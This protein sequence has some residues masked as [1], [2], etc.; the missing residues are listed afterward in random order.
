MVGFKINKNKINKKYKPTTNQK[1]QKYSL[2]NLP[3]KGLDQK[4]LIWHKF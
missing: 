4:E 3:R 1:I 2:S